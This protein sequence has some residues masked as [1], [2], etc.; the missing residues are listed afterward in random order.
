MAA[1]TVGQIA[2][3]NRQLLRRSNAAVPI[4]SGKFK[5]P[6]SSVK[7]ELRKEYAR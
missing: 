4:P 7:Q 5:K 3:H 6:R 1:K 2:A